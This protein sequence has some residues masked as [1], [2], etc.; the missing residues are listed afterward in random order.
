MIFNKQVIS[1]NNRLPNQDWQYY[2]G[3]DFAWI[4]EPEKLNYAND[5]EKGYKKK[6]CERM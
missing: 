2:L 5:E 4:K 3:L 6:N 1:N